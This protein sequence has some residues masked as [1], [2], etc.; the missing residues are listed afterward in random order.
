GGQLSAGRM[1]G[2]WALHEGCLQLRGE[3]GERQ[4]SMSQAQPSRANISS[5]I[6]IFSF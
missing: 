5:A 6:V 1:H 3:A 4:V 2:Y